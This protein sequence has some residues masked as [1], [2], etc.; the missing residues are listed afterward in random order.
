MRR[1]VGGG[2]SLAVVSLLLTWLNLPTITSNFVPEY[3]GIRRG[4]IERTVPIVRVTERKKEDYRNIKWVLDKDGNKEVIGTQ[5]NFKTPPETIEDIVQ[6]DFGME[7]ADPKKTYLTVWEKVAL[8]RMVP[9]KRAIEKHSNFYEVNP[10]WS[11]MVFNLE[12]LLDPTDV[13]RKSNDYGLGQVK[14]DSFNFAKLKGTNKDEVYFF[15]PDLNP[16]KSIFDPET[17][18]IV[19]LMLHRWNMERYDLESSDQ[20]YAIYV[21][22]KNRGLTEIL[23]ISKYTEKLV[24]AL[25]QRFDTYKRI[26]PFFCM[27]AGEVEEIKDPEVREYM[28]LYHQN[29]PI[30]EAYT[31][32]LDYSLSRIEKV[33]R[34]LMGEVL[35][36]DN[37]V[38][39]V[40]TLEIAFDRD[41]KDNIT[42]LQKIGK[43]FKKYARSTEQANRIK[44]SYKLLTTYIKEGIPKLKS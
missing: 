36:Y 11:L 29:L 26:I 35:L 19:S 31:R 28:T 27:N 7:A 43:R 25:H 20:A 3:D 12:S 13:N 8:S 17:N 30:P 18:I 1:I 6:R 40:K 34:P 22:G 16:N 14:V 23:G 38:S 4:P 2:V 21:R 15:S 10:M 37:C 32:L 33:K 41:Q 44:R 42:K 5:P 9:L 39:Y 24:E